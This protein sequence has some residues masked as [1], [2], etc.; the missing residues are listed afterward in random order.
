VIGQNSVIQQKIESL[1]PVKNS[2]DFYNLR[3]QVEALVKPGKK[4]FLWSDNLYLTLTSAQVW[5]ES[6]GD[7]KQQLLAWYYLQMYHNNHLDDNEVIALGKRLLKNKEFFKMPEST[8]SLLALNS[9][10]RRKGFYQQQL[11]IINQLLASNQKFGFEARPGTYGYYNDLALVYYNLG[12]FDLARKNFLKQAHDF[13]GAKDY[14]RLSSMINNVGLSYAKENKLDS[15]QI[16]YKKALSIL[17]NNEIEDPYYTKAYV[18]HFQQVIKANMATIQMN[19]GNFENVENIFRKELSSSKKVKE[20]RTTL[21]AYYSLTN[22]YYLTHQFEMA[23][24]Y[25]DSTLNFEK[26][27]ANPYNKQNTLLLKAKS[28]NKLGNAP[29]AL[30]YF[31]RVW[32]L[33]DSIFKENQK[34]NFSKAT[35]EFNFIE[36]E[37]QLQQSKKI[38]QQQEEINFFQAVVLSIS[39]IALMTIGIFLFKT[40]KNNKLIASQKKELTRNLREKEVMLNEIHHRIKNNLQ[41]ISGIL[42]L[43][44]NKIGSE[45]KS[46]IFKESQ[47]YIESIFLVHDL[48]YEQDELASLDMQDYFTRL[49][50]LL[51]KSYPSLSIKNFVSAK[52]ISMTLAQA[53]P[54]GLITCELI[55]NSLKHAFKNTGSIKIELNQQAKKF[56]F[57]YSDSGT[58]YKN[59]EDESTYNTG[60]NL[61]QILA[62]DL[63]AKITFPKTSGFCLQLNFEIDGE[64]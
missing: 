49:C 55:T 36:T 19:N 25:A 45:E 51:I 21:D 13:E 17:H 9:S 10:Y 6:N 37:K 30:I 5:A 23:L 44:S 61:V 32:N 34:N 27:Y 43:Q 50:E 54:L 53:T 42:E 57:F 11:K 29:Q 12:Q 26:R 4:E 64:Q 35:A 8:F 60:M 59:P 7:R 14:F 63:D 24:T 22:Y 58:G 56:T 16:F 33:R 47:D 52:T 20:P 41:M 48:L 31:E 39:L 28:L 1:Y 15:A 3:S 2:Q 46:D 18:Q 40:I 62:E 38:V